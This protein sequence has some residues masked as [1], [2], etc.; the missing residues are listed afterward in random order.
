MPLKVEPPFRQHK[1]TYGFCRVSTLPTAGLDKYVWDQN[2]QKISYLVDQFL[3]TKTKA[4]VQWSGIN[5]IGFWNVG[6]ANAWN[7]VCIYLITRCFGVNLFNEEPMY[8]IPFLPAFWWMYS[9]KFSSHMLL[10]SLLLGRG[11]IKTCDAI[12]CHL[13]YVS[14]LPLELFPS[15]FPVSIWEAWNLFQ[16]T[17]DGTTLFKVT[18]PIYT[19][20]A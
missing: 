19:I 20:E 10:F 14:C 1:P 16:M 6:H 4:W 17:S 3:R 8:K 9:F 2:T 13:K 15:F 11:Y 12:R 5:P 18:K 7:L